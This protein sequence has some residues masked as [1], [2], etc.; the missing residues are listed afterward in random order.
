MA[1]KQSVRDAWVAALRSGQYQQGQYYLKDN[2][3]RYCCLGVLGEVLGVPV[4]GEDAYASSNIHSPAYTFCRRAGLDTGLLM[5]L[6]DKNDAMEDIFTH[7][8]P[9]PA[10]ADYIETHV[11][12]E[13]D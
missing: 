2:E 11:P 1:M 10:I 13:Q 9:F 12:A 5:G 8:W 7:K 4:P 3:G 6:S